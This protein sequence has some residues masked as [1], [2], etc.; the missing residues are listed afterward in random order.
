MGG[1][2]ALPKRFEGRPANAWSP[3]EAGNGKNR[4]RGFRAQIGHEA[5][6]S[7]A[8]KILCPGKPSVPGTRGQLVSLLGSEVVL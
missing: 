4:S 6:P 7:L 2:R 1:W 3:K 5:V 8:L